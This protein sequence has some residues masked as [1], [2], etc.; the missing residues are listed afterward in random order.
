MPDNAFLFY[1]GHFSKTPPNAIS[2]QRMLN[3]FFRFPFRVFQFQGQWLQLNLDQMS[4]M[5]GSGASN[6]RLGVDSLAGARVWNLESLVRFRIGPVSYRWFQELMPGKKKLLQIAQ[7]VRQYVGIALETEY[8]IVLAKD[9]VPQLR[10]PDRD[11]TQVGPMLGRNTWL[12][13]GH[14]ADD[15]DEAVFRCSGSPDIDIVSAS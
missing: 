2:L 12:L 1:S 9:D 3:E 10:I 15:R 4:R 8:Q 13:S 11:S 6:N 5:G 7:F 14:S